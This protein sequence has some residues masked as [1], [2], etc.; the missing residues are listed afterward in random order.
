MIVGNNQVKNWQNYQRQLKWTDKRRSFLSR[1]PILGMYTAGCLLFFMFMFYTGSW[2]YAHLKDYD[3]QAWKGTKKEEIKPAG[4]TREDLPLLLADLKLS[5]SP[6]SGDYI[7]TDN[8]SELVANT[9]LDT[10]LQNYIARLLNRSMTNQA[11]VVV[12]RPDNGQVLAMVSYAK[13]GSVTGG[14]LCLQAGQPAASLFKIV[15]AA[16][17][18]EA[19]EFIPNTPLYF[20]GGKY[21]LYKKQLTQ[22]KNRYTN[23]TSLGGAFSGSINPVFGRLGIDLGQELLSNYSDKF[24]FNYKIPFDLSFQESFIAVPDDDFGLAEI[25]SGFNKRTLIS[26][27][28]AA[29]MTSAVVNNGIIMVPWMVVDVKDQSDQVLYKSSPAILSRAVTQDTAVKLKALMRETVKSGTVRKAFQSLMKKRVF[30]TMDMGAKTGT[31]NDRLD[32]YKFDWLTSY[33]IPGEGSGI[34]IAVLAIHG[35]KLGIRAKDLARYIINY[36]FTS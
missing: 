10:S 28:H 18:I 29:L 33:A 6:V 31:I 17:A 34:C 21:T 1:L 26:P 35:E 20:N 22:D 27:L 11:A 9:S 23:K 8:T 32:K 24:L 30:K 16:A 3:I 15:A 4:L 13:D 5:P 7:L 14:D 2:I 19:R 36:H 12:L 25:A